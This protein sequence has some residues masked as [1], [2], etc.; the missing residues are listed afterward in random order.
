[1]RYCEEENFHTPIP[2]TTMLIPVLYIHEGKRIVKWCNTEAGY[3]VT[4]RLLVM[5]LTWSRVLQSLTRRPT[6]GLS[7]RDSFRSYNSWSCGARGASEDVGGTGCKSRRW[8]EMGNM[9]SWSSITTQAGHDERDKM[10]LGG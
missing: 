1:M 9:R 2:K 4:L 10:N 8:E 6:G 3:K 5:K 7:F